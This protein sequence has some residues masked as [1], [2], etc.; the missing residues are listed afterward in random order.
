M[1]ENENNAQ[2]ESGDCDDIQPCCQSASEGGDCCSAGSGGRGKSL[3][4]AISVV[5]LLLAGAV[6]A[7]SLLKK[8]G[9]TAVVPEQAASSL[10]VVNLSEQADSSIGSAATSEQPSKT[11]DVLCG[12]NLDSMKSLAKLAGERKANVVFILLVG[13]DGELAR[14]A[15]EQTDAVVSKL[16]EQGKAVAAFTL[17]QNAEGYDQLAKQV[18]SLPSVIV[19]GRGYGAAVVTGK[20]NEAALL[21]AFVR[22][23]SPT[24]CAPGSD[25]LCC[26]K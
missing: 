22:A 8:G 18:K 13:D 17:K 9:E 4:T 25:A 16:V 5:I 20:I 10:E 19:T 7:H 21:S 15:A 11:I 23:T 26:P 3:K 14:A 1:I 12:T 24:S 2:A 6:A